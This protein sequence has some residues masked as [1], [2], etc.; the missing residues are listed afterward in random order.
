MKFIWPR[1]WH[2][3]HCGLCGLHE[4]GRSPAYVQPGC[5]VSSAVNTPYNLPHGHM[6]GRMPIRSDDLNTRLV[7]AE[8][9][10]SPHRRKS[11][12]SI[13]PAP[14]LFLHAT[15]PCLASWMRRAACTDASDPSAVGPSCGVA[16]T[17][18]MARSSATAAGEI[19]HLLAHVVSMAAPGRMAAAHPWRSDSLR[20]SDRTG[21]I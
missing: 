4:Q 19:P 20:C 14:T 5:L 2:G 7:A 3:L 18:I 6:V 10:A 1:S 12:L 16:A 15:I 8:S 17:P 13:L 21:D 9:L 11:P